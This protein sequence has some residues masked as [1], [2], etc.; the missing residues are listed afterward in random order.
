MTLRILAI[1]L[2]TLEGISAESGQVA[3]DNASNRTGGPMELSW[4]PLQPFVLTMYQE[5][6]FSV[7]YTLYCNHS[8]DRYR[9]EISS[10]RHV[11]FTVRQDAIVLYCSNATDIL[12]NVTDTGPQVI[13]IPVTSSTTSPRYHVIQRKGLR[14]KLTLALYGELIGRALLDVKL[15]KVGNSLQ[16]ETTADRH[17]FNVVVF[18]KLGV[19]DTV[20]RVLI[21]IFIVFVTLAFGCKLD[22]DVVKENLRRPVAPAI[23]LCCQ[24]ILMPMIAFAIAKLVVPNDPAVA[25][26]IFISGVCPGGGVSNIYSHLLDGDLS[27]SITMTTICTIAALGMMPLWIYT[28][29]KVFTDELGGAT[30]MDIP[31]LNIFTALIILIVPLLVGVAIKYKLPRLTK[32]LMKIITPVTLFVIIILISVGIYTNLFIFKFFEPKV[33]LAGSLLPYCGYILSGII[34]LI[35]RQ[36][37]TK[38]KT[39]IIETG[40]QNQGVAILLMFTA[41]PPPDGEI[42]AVAPIASGV[43]TPLPLF[44]LT[45]IYQIY[46][47]CNKDKYASVPEKDA[48]KRGDVDLEVKNGTKIIVNGNREE[49]EMLQYD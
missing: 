35:L 25:L 12:M 17:V 48:T 37:W 3:P 11:V 32:V 9:V 4:G 26:G 14:G 6:T 47:R 46:K 13:P 40:I 33:I 29:G 36:S 16:N 27:L 44:V 38:V 15:Q 49:K 7:E 34:S 23:G 18:R 41:F 30:K 2:L 8:S 19:F 1:L 21:Y 10:K 31:F 22:I 39:I 28:L 20:F 24:Y 43:M 5:S 42:A 45:I